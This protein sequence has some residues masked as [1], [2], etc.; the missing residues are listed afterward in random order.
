V[1]KYLVTGAAGF[2]GSHLVEHLVGLGE[3][4]RGVDN[5]ATG[6]RENIEPF[7]EHIE[8]IQ[9]DLRD[10]AVCT[11]SVR[12]VDY[13]LHQA[14]IP[15]VPRSVEAP[16]ESHEANATA[17][18]NLL[19]AAQ[20]AGVKRVV[21]AGSSSAY[22][23]QSGDYK[24]EDM[25]PDPLSPYAA[26][27]LA[28]EQYCRVF[29][30]CYGLETVCLRYF[31]VFGPRQDLASMYSAVVPKFIAA[32]RAGEPPTIDGDGGQAR[33]FTYVENNVRANILAATVNFEARGQVYNVACGESITILELLEA[34][35]RIVG[36]QVNARFGPARVGD[37][38]LSKADIAR[39]RADLGYEVAV[40][41]DEGLS[42]TIAWYG[43]Q[44]LE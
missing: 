4:V 29:S 41:L 35:N 30:E 20:K 37:V 14:A 36:T 6:K 5:F 32:V 18:L 44:S 10:L 19:S 7:L 39:A 15:S 12:G 34:I 23:N 16:L 40:P 22:G 21:Y 24:R 11:R 43:A 2:I 1:A 13:V 25:T 27:K 17:T 28:G 26:S 33:D 9:G 3:S 31:N 8:F 38:R 42:R